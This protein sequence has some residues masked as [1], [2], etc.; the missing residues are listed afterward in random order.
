MKTFILLILWGLPFSFIAQTTLNISISGI[1]NTSGN[2]RLAFYC[3]SDDFNS[4]KPVFIKSVPKSQ[5]SKGTIYA[6]YVLK[7]GTYGIAILDDENS[8]HQM[9]YGLVLPKEGFGFSNYYHTGM[10]MPKFEKFRF[11]LAGEPKN[12]QVKLRYL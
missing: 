9:D 8:N 7:P 4:N 10:S 12:I 3:C 2:I 11:T 1:R 6:S 5:V